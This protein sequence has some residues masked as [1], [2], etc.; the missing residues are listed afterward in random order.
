[1]EEDVLFVYILQV[2]NFFTIDLIIQWID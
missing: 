1:L 2:S